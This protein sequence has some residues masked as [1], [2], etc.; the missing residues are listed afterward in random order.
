MCI[1]YFEKKR[2][3]YVFHKLNKKYASKTKQQEFVNL[4]WIRFPHHIFPNEEYVKSLITKFY[5]NDIHTQTLLSTYTFEGISQQSLSF[6]SITKY[7]NQNSQSQYYYLLQN[8]D[9]LYALK[10]YYNLLNKEYPYVEL[11][12]QYYNLEDE[13]YIS[14]LYT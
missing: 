10:K 9:I 1:P 3:T 12:Y 14:Q 11:S 7:D 2:N 6:P 4:K 13:K 8:I 5:K